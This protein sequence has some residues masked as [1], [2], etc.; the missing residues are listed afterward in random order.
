MLIPFGDR[1][2]SI[3]PTAYVHSSA[4][5]IG[6]VSIGAQSSV[7]FNVVLRGDV[8][9]IRIGARTNI[10]DGSVLHV[11]NNRWPVVVGNDVTVGHSAVLH[12]C[13]VG[14][15]CL[16]A[17]GAIVLDG[18]EVG[19][20]CLIGAG[21]LIAPGTKI[22]SGQLVLGRPA[23]PVRS[24]TAAEHAQLLESAAV[25]LAHAERYRGLGIV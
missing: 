10:Q 19:D 7:W 17:I 5:V 21:S 22:A 15:R 24:L 9:S 1:K 13:T 23:K 14:S 2:P 16:I 3:D 25:Y 6:D 4:Q 8:H 18:C 20:D 11:T 12:G